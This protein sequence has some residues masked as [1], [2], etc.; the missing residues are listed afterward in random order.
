MDEIARLQLVSR[1]Y[2]GLKP[3]VLLKLRK[4]R[5]LIDGGGKIL[6]WLFGVSTNEELDR[7]NRRVDSLSTEASAMVHALEE[8]TSLINESIWEIK[9]HRIGYKTPDL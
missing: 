9:G 5:A 2:E 4:K 1:N 8:H 6:N 3:T 7:V